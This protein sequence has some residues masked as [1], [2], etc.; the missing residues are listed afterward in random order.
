MK[1]VF[2]R[3]SANAARRAALLIGILIFALISTS[4]IFAQ[5]DFII[6]PDLRNYGTFDFRA[7]R[8][9]VEP[10]YAGAEDSIFSSADF[11][12]SYTFVVQKAVR[13]KRQLKN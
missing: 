10:S 4:S 6:A 8:K 13:D 11:S 2:S 1:F 9:I 5:A 12:G 7:G 3:L